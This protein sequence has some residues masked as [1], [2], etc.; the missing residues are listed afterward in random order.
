MVQ[1]ARAVVQ[2]G[3]LGDLFIIQGSYLQDWLLFPTDWNWRLEPG[4]GRKPARGRRYRL[5]LAGPDHLHHRPARGG[6]V[7]RFQHLPPDPQET[8]Q[9]SRDLHRQ[10]A[11]ADGLR[12]SADPHRGLCQRAAALRERGA[13]RADGLAGLRRAQEPAVLSRSTAPSRRW[14]GI[15]SGRTSCGSATA[16]R[17]TSCCSRTHRCSAPR[18]ALS[19]SYP[20]GHNE[21][22]PD[23]FKQLYAKVYDYILTGDY[24][25]QADF[26]T[27]AD[28]HYEMQLCEAIQ[29]SATE[30]TWVKV[31]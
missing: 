3:E 12:R 11:P 16:P 21:G 27:F 7:C 17:P 29:R 8:E 20:G 14:P 9:A 2:S 23:T 28:G 19:T 31:A 1:Q 6:G 10:D 30:K 25:K 22:F 13:R 24:D 4:A 26:P 5:A 15:R 18:R